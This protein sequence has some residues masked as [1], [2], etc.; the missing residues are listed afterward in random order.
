MGEVHLSFQEI[1]A[2]FRPKI[3]QYLNSM[4]G[5]FEAEDLTQEVFVKVSRSLSTF[6]GESQLSTWIYRIAANT[7]LDRL[8]NPA[9]KHSAQENLSV[10]E[11]FDGD[12]ALGGKEIV[13]QDTWTGEEKLSL[14]QQLFFKQR[15]ECYQSLI[16]KLPVNY[17][18]VVALNEFGELAVSEIA[19][20]LGMSPE[21][22]KIRLHRGRARLLQEV[23]LHCTPEDW[24]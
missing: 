23:R 19:E 22:V 3:L 1:Y 10:L 13:D 21:V 16:K 7:A 24:L 8:R 14:E 4:V 11:P 18:F 15:S 6:R 20:V 9:F 17:R 2:E 12:P 5:E